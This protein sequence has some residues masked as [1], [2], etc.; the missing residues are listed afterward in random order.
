MPHFLCKMTLPRPDFPATTS[1]NQQRVMKAHG[2]DLRGLAE[3][4]AIVCDGPVDDPRGGWGL[5]IFDVGSLQAVRTLRDRGDERAS[6]ED[7]PDR[8]VMRIPD[9]SDCRRDSLDR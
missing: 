8:R 5:S 6:H 9:A 7:E 3:H 4:G 1:E 2:D